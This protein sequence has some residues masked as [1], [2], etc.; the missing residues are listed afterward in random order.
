MLRRQGSQVTILSGAPLSLVPA[1]GLKEQPVVPL[2]GFFFPGISNMITSWKRRQLFRIFIAVFL[3]F[4]AM[5]LQAWGQATASSPLQGAPSGM[6]APERVE[7]GIYPISI[8]DLDTSRNT[9][10]IDFYL[11]V[12]WTGDI[13]PL[14]SLRFVNMVDEW[15]SLKEQ[16]STRHTTLPDGTKYQFLRI[17][18]RFVH[19]F[20][21]QQYPFDR[22]TLRIVIEDEEHATDELVYSID[23]DNS[24]IDKDLRIAGWDIT[25][26]S[27]EIDERHYDSNF[28]VSGLNSAY[29]IAAL[30]VEIARPASLFYWKL[31][32]PLTIVLL[33]ALSSLLLPTLQ[34]DARAALVAS[35]L[36]TAVFLQRTYLDSLPDIGYLVVM[37]QIYLVAYFVILVCLF[38]VAYTFLMTRKADDG[39]RNRYGKSDRIVMVLLLLLFMCTSFVIV[40]IA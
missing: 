23:K 18:G 12:K 8:Y 39:E 38:R 27:T 35:G 22:Q 31:M 32:T 36:L 19:A 37:D 21:F 3:A 9:Y 4:E 1:L 7:I 6:S 10:F 14:Q 24:K 29:S 13:D 15:D 25:Q 33:A 16:V 17:E 34:L 11:W 20:D 2:T 30:S 26:V 5:T 40:G 28:G